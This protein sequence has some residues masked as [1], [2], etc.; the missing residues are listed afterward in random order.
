MPVQRCSSLPDRICQMFGVDQF[1]SKTGGGQSGPPRFKCSY[2]SSLIKTQLTLPK[3]PTMHVR[4][5]VWLP[6][7]TKI[8]KGALNALSCVFMVWESWCLRMLWARDPSEPVWL[9]VVPAEYGESSKVVRTECVKNLN[10]NWKP[11]KTAERG[12][13][14]GSICCTR[15]EWC[16]Q[17]LYVGNWRLL[18]QCRPFIWG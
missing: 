5:H 16:V 4:L 13:H 17:F 15:V 3:T 10:A 2:A 7:T 1:I 14:T 11:A 8:C 12:K 9:V 6:C 18:G